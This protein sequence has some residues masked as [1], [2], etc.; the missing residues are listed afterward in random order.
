MV[1]IH[2]P[3]NREVGVDAGGGDSAIDGAWLARVDQLVLDKMHKRMIATH[4]LTCVTHTRTEHAQRRWTL[5]CVK[6][7]KKERFESGVLTEGAIDVAEDP[8]SIGLGS[9]H[10]C[11]HLRLYRS[12]RLVEG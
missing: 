3:T 4:V 6:G 7:M 5:P 1:V 11:V 12:G 2:R 8:F 10:E 9:K